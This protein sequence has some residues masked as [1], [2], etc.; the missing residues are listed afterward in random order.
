[1]SKYILVTGAAGF[2]GFYLSLALK[3]RGDHV[4][5]FDNFNAYYSP[6]LKRRRAALLEEQGI[7][8]IEGDLNDRE[9]LGRLFKTPPFACVLHLAAQAGVRYARSNPDAYL[10]SNINGFLSLLETLRSYNHVKL[11]YASSSSVYGRNTTIPF[12]IEDTTDKPANLYAV[13]K[14]TNELMAYSY[15]HLFGIPTTGLRFFTVYGPW[16]R[17]DMAY[18]TFTQAILEGKPIHLF[19]NGNMQR[20]FT[21]IDDIV[22]GTLAALDYNGEYE[23]F[24]LGN[25]RPT[26]L[27]SFVEILEKILGRKAIKIFEGPSAGEVETTYADISASEKKLGFRPTTELETGLSKFVEWYSSSQISD[28][29][30]ADILNRQGIL[31]NSSCSKLTFVDFE[32]D[33]K[34]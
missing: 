28:I 6:E 12:S 25:H 26:P 20:D 15:H 34:Q 29:N 13:T 8:V 30:D 14:K 33:G 3:N 2:I 24:N 18:Y 7:T 27:L 32:Q 10:T 31:I 4:V 22:R 11:I 21:Y 1:M 9:L 5:G 16:G 19:N 17:P 23:L